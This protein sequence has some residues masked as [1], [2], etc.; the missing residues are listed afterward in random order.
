MADNSALRQSI[1]DLLQNLASQPLATGAIALLNTLGYSSDKTAELGNTAEA[2][3][4]SIEQFRPEL[5]SINR[6]KVHAN[7]W[8]SC[9]FLFQLTNDEIPSLALGQSPVG[10]DGKLTQGQIESFV[11]LAIDLQGEGWSRSQLATIA[12]ELNKR[13]PM[14]AI[15]LFRQEELFSLAVIDRRQNLRDASRDVIDSRITVIKDVRLTAPHRAHIDIL[16]SFALVNLG[17]KRRPG[18][19]RELYDAWIDT[20][21]TQKLNKDFYRQ[22]AW[23]YMWATKEVEFPKGG[24]PDRNAI[25]VIRLLTRLIFVWFIKERGLVPNTLFEREALRGLLKQAP[26]TASDESNYYHA[27]LQNLFFATLN[28]EMGNDRRWAKTGNGMKGDYLIS[29]VYRH[30]DAFKHPET[31][32]Q[33]Y[34]A[35]VPFLNGGLFECLDEQLTDEELARRPELRKLVVQEG[36]GLVLRIDGFSRRPDAQAK[37]PNKLFF[38]GTDDAALNTEFETKGKRYPVKGLIDLLDSYKFTVDENTPLDEEVALDPELLGKVFENLLASYNPDTRSSARKQSGSFYTPREVVDYMVDEAL[39]A[40]FTRHLPNGEQREQDLRQLLSHADTEHAFGEAEADA[41]VL[42]IEQLKVLDPACGSGA[43][44]MG[45]LAKLFVALKKLD[46][47]NRRWR[48]QNLAPL[49]QRL[50]LAKRTPDPVQRDAEIEDAEAALEKHK[51]DFADPAYADYTRKLY[52]IEKCIFGSDIQPIAVQ[53]A[54][55]RFF[56][57]LIVSQPIDRSKPNWNITPLPNLETKIVAANTLFG[58]PRHGAQGSLLDDPAIAEKEAELRDANAAYFTSRTRATK[59]RRKEKVQRLHEELVTLLKLDGF[60]T[61]NDAER[62]A[63]WDPFDQN[64]YAD[65]FD[66]EWMFGMPRAQDNSEAVFD[67]VIANPPYVRQEEIKELKPLLKDVYKYECYTGT[68]DLFVYFYER[69]VKLLKPQGVLSFIT[70][71]KW[72]RTKYG[73]NLRLFMATHT[74]L[75]NIID[76][77]DEAVFTAIAYPTIVIAT[78]REKPLNPPPATDQVRALNWTQEH[79]VEEFPAVFQAA[80]F[81]VPQ[82]KLTKAGWQL[83]PPGKRQLLERVIST[84]TP[85]RKYLGARVSRGIT[86]GLN[87]AFV[88]DSQTRA[89][90]IAEDAKSAEII[91]PFMR[92]NDVKRWKARPEDLWLIFTRRPFPVDQYPAIKKYLSSF[93]VQLMPKPENWDDGRDGKWKGRKAGSYEWFEI[94]DNI[95]YWQEFERPKIVSTKVSIEPT[96]SLDNEAYYLG[97]TAYFI[98]ADDDR[99][100]LLALLNS[101]VSAYYARGRFVGKQNGYYEV[102]PEALEAFPTPSATVQHKK[103][104]GVAANCVLATSDPQYEQLINGLVFELF[105]PDELHAANILLFDACEKA[106]VGKLSNLEDKAL[107]T[108]ATE[109]AGRIFATDHPIYAMLFD[110]QALEVVRIIEG[111]E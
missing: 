39:I 97:N 77:G 85:L 61:A 65:F 62:M 22:L 51:K 15:F 20:L 21:S 84:G 44:P 106:G 88:I 25:G 111:K 70:S 48:D 99:L 14:P 72:Y 35:N 56:I 108:A 4:S 100:Y 12:R 3:L 17:D 102:Q 96:F 36:K 86:T 93:Q 107:V 6:A 53:I 50:A 2:L 92:G 75:K 79:P 27:I 82:V 37:V 43:F 40:Y 101:S 38:G 67:I 58:V 103:V 19:F 68:A 109:L 31:V 63:C 5:G 110:L 74:R 9:A 76:F 95:A 66:V 18:N 81:N 60:V 55:L 87:E 11:F 41:L 54:K 42:A 16:A 47:D 69:S 59:K 57:A 32:L 13:F 83:E 91:K 78:R 30:H 1:Q 105:F 89:R 23:W 52:L 33:D 28:Q 34:F 73:E 104:L 64:R 10:A 45:V 7:R 94:Q 29:L 80:A 49:Q 24:G 71:N 98:P 46:P 26:D 8:K 90:L